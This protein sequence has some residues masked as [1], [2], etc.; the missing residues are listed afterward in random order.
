ML[1]VA[2]AFQPL[3]RAQAD[4]APETTSSFAVQ[5]LAGEVSVSVE[6]THT[7]ALLQAVLRGQQA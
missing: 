7:Q 2:S 5:D 4:H 1:F 6:E 3:H